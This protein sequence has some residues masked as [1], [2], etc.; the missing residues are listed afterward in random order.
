M[1]IFQGVR[2]VGPFLLAFS[3]IPLL[4]LG[5]YTGSLLL[6]KNAQET[7]IFQLVH[8]RRQAYMPAFL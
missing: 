8:S 3:G 7:S 5:S 1:Q 4:P 6:I 2:P